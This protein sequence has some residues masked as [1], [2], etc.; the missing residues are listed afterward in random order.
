MRLY[1][2]ILAY[3]LKEIVTQLPNPLLSPCPD[4][5]YYE[6]QKEADKWVGVITIHTT[7]KLIG[8]WLTVKLDRKAELLGNWFGETYSTDN[9]DF[10]IS[11]PDYILEAGPPVTIRFFIKYN[12]IGTPPKLDTIR[13][14][15]LTI[16]PQQQHNLKTTTPKLHIS[17]PKP[18]SSPTI[19]VHTES[20][21]YVTPNTNK[22]VSTSSL[23][24]DASLNYFNAPAVE[25]DGISDSSLHIDKPD[26]YIP[27][28]GNVG[29][30]HPTDNS[31]SLK[32]NLL[33]NYNP[34]I[35]K[36][37]R[38][39]DGS[40]SASSST[41][42]KPV[43]GVDT[44]IANNYNS[45]INKPIGTVN[46]N[47]PITNN[48]NIGTGNYYPP[49][50]RPNGKLPEYPTNNGKNRYPVETKPVDHLHLGY[51]VA[52]TGD[53]GTNVPTG[54]DGS[55]TNLNNIYG[56]S[57]IKVLGTNT[58]NPNTIP[59]REVSV[60]SLYNELNV[61]ANISPSDIQT[62]SHN[63]ESHDSEEDFF[64]GDF[65]AD[66]G[67]STENNIKKPLLEK[68]P[69]VGCGTVAL[70]PKA[71]IAYGQ[72]TTPGQWPWH[73]AV[74]HTKGITLMYICGAS[75]ISQT[76]VLIAAHCVTKP[77]AATPV[78]PESIL[79]YFGKYNLRT[80][81]PETQDRDV[82]QIIIHPNFNSSMFFNDIAIIKLS[83]PVEI[84]DYVRPVCLWEDDTNLESIVNKD[85]TVIGW[86]FDENKKI[87][88][89][90]MQAK[91]PVVSTIQCIYS[92]RDFFAQFTSD[93]NFCAGFRNGTSVCNGDSGG[94]MVF[95]KKSLSGQNPV[96]QI[97]GIVSVGVA[98]Q[99]EG[100]CD[101][102]QYVIFTDVAKYLPWIKEVMNSN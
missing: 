7:E 102:S 67:A 98:L 62:P 11:N 14:N 9:I 78:E 77:R 44:I 24:K 69:R 51:N 91:M 37:I 88:E 6:P 93:T 29:Y 8:I 20:D 95:P 63:S 13:L 81:G 26:V 68:Q 56:T 83:R 21:K 22:V 39:T 71:F 89:K 30:T 60:P 5:F 57:E 46:S 82:S 1:L 96:W 43:K 53:Y 38:A 41:I 36:P 23:N 74:Y 85:G 48:P 65:N 64:P 70:K 16:C 76:H 32:D 97:R 17:K 80:F 12:P 19:V 92:N 58:R 2:L 47:Y 42:A 59:N 55:I 99:T 35:D 18:T 4:I 84:T 66:K 33:P 10:R 101:T 27:S 3:M 94:S 15:G 75:L 72:D 87:S 79:V 52:T 40:F 25:G 50:T 61:H 90:L 54:S 31:N 86:G 34:S 100:I 73:A 45:P 28:I 49:I